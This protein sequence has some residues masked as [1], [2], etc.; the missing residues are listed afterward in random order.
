MAPLLT[1][2]PDCAWASTDAPEIKGKN[3]SVTLRDSVDLSLSCSGDKLLSDF[4]SQYRGCLGIQG[5]CSPNIMTILNVSW[6][7]TVSCFSP[8]PDIYLGLHSEPGVY[9]IT[10]LA[11]GGDHHVSAVGLN[12]E[13]P[14]K[15]LVRDMALV[16]F[17]AA[18]KM[19]AGYDHSDENS[20]KFLTTIICYAKEIYA[21]IEGPSHG[22]SDTRVYIL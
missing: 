5:A 17:K 19:A 13:V 20:E 14:V 4:I 16:Q 21:T 2:T 1:N 7:V 11:H 10:R 8:A 3:S 9:F 22:N 6:M 15:N 18:R 12:C